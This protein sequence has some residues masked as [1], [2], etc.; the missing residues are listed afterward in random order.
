[1]TNSSGSSIPTTLSRSRADAA[2]SI[3]MGAFTI[4]KS[5]GPVSYSHWVPDASGRLWCGHN[6]DVALVLTADQLDP[7]GMVLDYG[8]L[9]PMKDL[10]KRTVDHRHL[11]DVVGG[12]PAQCDHAGLQLT[13]FVYKQLVTDPDL[14]FRALVHDVRVADAWPDSLPLAWQLAWQGVVEPWRFHA[15]HR[16]DGLP[17]GHQCGR[18]HGHG[19]RAGAQVDKRHAPDVAA[20]SRILRPAEEFVRTRLHQHSLNEA[21][22]GLNSTAEQA[23]RFLYHQFTENLGIRGITRVL[24]AETP[25]TLAE[26]RP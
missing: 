21:L 14:P 8:Q 9:D 11:D 7:V 13:D 16:L 10:L 18:D 17:E 3:P 5:F 2:A 19:Y 20:A 23:A 25:K 15:H 22:G 4:T 1:M 24:I 6:A 26:Y 12:P